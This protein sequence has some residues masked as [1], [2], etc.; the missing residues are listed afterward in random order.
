MSLKA[1]KSVRGQRR[2][3]G[4]TL[5]LLAVLVL[6]GLG[7]AVGW[8]WFRIHSQGSD[9]V[10]VIGTALLPHNYANAMMTGDLVLHQIERAAK[11][12]KVDVPRS[13][14]YL[15]IRG[16][17]KPSGDTVHVLVKVFIPAKIA[18][19][20]NFPIYRKVEQTYPLQRLP[21]GFMQYETPPQSDIAKELAARKD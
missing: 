6:L 18:G 15:S 2:P 10:K 1:R 11:L 12:E 3:M 20:I 4:G 13:R 8:Q 5:T 16:E 9:I 17:R 19:F 7:G 14:T 21:A